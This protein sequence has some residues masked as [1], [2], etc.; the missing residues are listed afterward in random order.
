MATPHISMYGWCCLKKQNL[1]LIG[2]LLL[3]KLLYLMLWIHRY[4]MQV[5]IGLLFTHSI[6]DSNCLN[7]PTVFLGE[8]E[9][10]IVTRKS[11]TTLRF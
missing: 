5:I 6:A 3:L 11:L 9:L 4:S 8:K 10:N 2:Q 1:A 7:V